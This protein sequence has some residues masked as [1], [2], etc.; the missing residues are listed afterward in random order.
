MGTGKSGNSMEFLG[1]RNQEKPRAGP[2]PREKSQLWECGEGIELSILLGSK[3]QEFLGKIWEEPSL[4]TWE[5]SGEIFLGISG[6]LIHGKTLQSHGIF[7]SWEFCRELCR[8]NPRFLLE[9]VFLSQFPLRNSR[10][11]R[12]RRRF[13]IP[14]SQNFVIILGFPIPS[15]FQNSQILGLFLA[16]GGWGCVDPAGIFP[17]GMLGFGNVGIP[18]TV[19]SGMLEFGKVKIPGILA[20]G[21]LEFLW[22]C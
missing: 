22:K 5:C 17:W 13:G 8:N 7:F 18:G 9:L 3:P 6:S 14:K 16:P 20:S 4:G 21:R 19:P 15:Q 12:Q 1:N 2:D 11:S 10:F